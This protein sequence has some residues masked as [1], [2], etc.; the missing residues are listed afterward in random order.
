MSIRRMSFYLF[1][2]FLVVLVIGIPIK[3]QY[4]ETQQTDTE[5]ISGRNVNMVSGT[6]LPGG[7]PW[8]QR[9]NEPSIAVSSRN[10]QHLLAGANDYRTVDMPI[11]E[12]ELPGKVPTAMV[13]DAWLGVFKS[14]DGGESWTSTMLPGY[15]QDPNTNPLKGYR[16]AADPVVRSGPNGLFYYSG[17]A[18]NRDTNLGVVFVARFIDNNNKEGGNTIQYVDTKIIARGTA[19]KFLD[20]PWIAID[21]PRIP[22]TNITIAGQTFPRHNVYIAYSAFSGQAATLGNIMFARSNDCGKTWGTPIKISTGNFA[23]QG[24]TIAIKPVLG[25]VLVAWRRF[26]QTGKTPDQ[27]YV[28]QSFTRGLSFQSPIKVADIPPFDQPTTDETQS[29]PGTGLGF[30]FRTNSY[31][32]M[33]VDKSGHVYLA[34][35]QRGL[36]AG[37]GARIMLSSSHVGSNWTSPQPIDPG[38]LSFLGHQIMPSLSFA[39]SKLIVVWYDQRNDVSG[40]EYGFNNWILDDLPYRHTMD[41]WAGEA[42]TSNYPNLVWKFTQVSRYLYSVLRDDSGNIIFEDGNPIIFPVQFNCVNYPLFKG[43]HN[44]FMGDYVDVAASPSFRLDT[45]RNWIFNT[46]SSNSPVFHVAWTD[47]RDVRPPLPPYYNWT[48]YTPPNYSNSNFDTPDRT[49][50][51]QGGSGNEPGMRN[52]NIYTSRI[53]WGIEAGSPTNDK[54]LNLDVG[55]AFVVFVKNN[56]EFLRS[57]RLTIAGQPAGG[58]AS[59]L[60]FE[61]LTTLDVNIAPYST[62]SRPVFIDSS[63]INASVTIN[64]DEIDASGNII[65]GGLKSSVLINGDPTN[66]NVPIGEET[67]NPNIVNQAN[68]NI[69]NWYVNPNIVNPNIVNPNIVNPNIVNPNIVNPNIRNSN[70]VNPNIVNPNIVNPNIVNPNIVNPNIVNPNIVNPNI[71]NPNIRNAALEDL[72][73]TDVEWT[74]RNDG[75]ATTS[76]TLKALAK[77]SPPEGVYAQLLVYRVHLTPAVAGAELSSAEGINACELKQEPHHELIL[78]IVNPNIRNPNIVNPNIV[79]PNIVNSSIENATFSVAPGEEVIVDLRVLD[80][81]V[82]SSSPTTFMTLSSKSSLQ[83][84]NVQDFIDS[85]G[86]AV[87]SQAVNSVDAAQGIE[88]PPAAATTLVIGTSALP[89]GIVN[90]GYTATLQAYGGDG[91]YYWFLNSGELPLGLTLGVG[92]TITGTP[93]TAGTYYF[94]VRVDSG[95]QFDTQQYSIFVDSDSTADPLTI[96]TTSL[97]NG[98][99]GFWYG[100]TLEATGGVWPRTWSLA[101]GA[102]PDGLSLDSGGVISGTPIATGSSTFTVKVNDA[103]STSVTKQLTIDLVAA[104][105]ANFTISGTVYDGQGQPLEGAVMRGLPNTPVTDANGNYQDTVPE[106]WTGTVIP[107]KANVAFSPPGRTYTNISQSWLNEDYNVPS[108]GYTVSGKVYYSTTLLDGISVEL[109]LGNDWYNPLQTT[110][111]A[112]G[113]AYSFSS[114]APDSY[115]VKVN[116]PSPEYIGWTASS[117]EVVNANVTQDMDLPKIIDLLTPPIGSTVYTQHPTLTWTANPQA[118]TYIVQINRTQNWFP[119]IEQTTVFTNSY[120]VQTTLDFGT[121]YTWQVDAN[122]ANGHHVGTTSTAFNFTPVMIP[123]SGEI[124]IKQGPI[125]IPTGGTYDFGSRANDSHT[126][127]T[128]TIE[129][130]GNGDLILTSNPL[131]M[132]SGTNADQFQVT[133]LPSTPIIAGS[134]TIFTVQFSPTSLGLKTASISIP[135]T[136][137]DENP[138]EVPLSGDCPTGLIFSTFDQDTVDQP[139][140]LGGP[141]N[142]PTSLYQLEGG[143]MGTPVD[144]TINIRAAADGITTQPVEINNQGKSKYFGSVNYRLGSTMSSGTVILE[145]TITFDKLLSAG[146]YDFFLQTINSE[147]AVPTRLHM[148]PGGAIRAGGTQIGSYQANVPFRVRESIDFATQKWSVV[149]DNEMNGFSDDPVF[150]NFAFENINPPYD[151][152]EVWASFSCYNTAGLASCAYDDIFLGYIPPGGGQ[153]GLSDYSSGFDGLTRSSNGHRISSIS[154]RSGN[155]E[156]LFMKADV[157]SQKHLPKN[158]APDIGPNPRSSWVRSFEHPWQK[159]QWHTGPLR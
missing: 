92:G 43:G 107:F 16:T 133:T 115:N 110:T 97:P 96:I 3:S 120:T 154:N 9:Q 2:A 55:R 29:L 76:F 48:V 140:Q 26:A 62:I 84:F 25:E 86:F 124:N 152:R 77:K 37:G 42:D 50:C 19:D 4:V 156:I 158:P 87:T 135:N 130:T 33:T 91:T 155:D 141:P 106:H 138:Y 105:G 125:G 57:Y 1:F 73:I 128:F 144:G 6:T 41:V 127:V 129:N 10:P 101:S 88:T 90:T 71:V 28:A 126:S 11:S 75:N 12:G 23:H 64:I 78:N 82:A 139:P 136:D 153:M 147:N 100:A 30:A 119:T 70:I 14:Y 123:A 53:T 131:I 122:D 118:S 109:I 103:A 134:S 85:L 145:A 8:L 44:P 116:G 32:T 36:G 99:Q 95:D 74:V 18:F 27:I 66:P 151:I 47:N 108:G 148:F 65:A 58:Q 142:H 69:V 51:S 89:D 149:I 93:T 59:F 63:D 94:I 72:S 38:A 150:S 24:A 83:A 54:P 22:F 137:S 52:Q 20:K 114:V 79:N 143:P 15:P 113:G 35:S 121:N 40:A 132:I 68:P 13:G 46:D 157:Q 102:L 98:V 21:Q 17:I 60:Q 159:K 31:P 80:T 111:S 112:N 5:L 104:T 49:N 61:L 81:G 7:D 117:V 39:A 67:H 45:W 146:E 34:W 56:T